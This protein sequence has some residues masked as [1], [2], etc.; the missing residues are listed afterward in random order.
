MEVIKVGGA[1]L[2]DVRGFNRFIK[3]LDEYHSKKII[4]VISAFSTST[5]DLSAIAQ[6]AS[7]G[8]AAKAYNLLNNFTKS[9]LELAKTLIKKPSDYDSLNNNLSILVEKLVSIIEGVIITKELSS[10]IKDLI[11]SFGEMFALQIV[12]SLLSA[13][14][15]KH[16]TI[17]ATKIIIT[18]S[19]FGNAKPNESVTERNVRLHL[20]PAFGECNIVLTQGFVASD[21]KGD[22]TTMGIESSNLTAVMLAKMSGAKKLTFWTDVPGIRSADPKL[23]KETSLIKGMSYSEAYTA[24]ALGL[25]LIYPSMIDYAKD[26]SIKLIYRSAFEKWDDATTISHKNSNPSIIITSDGYSLLEVIPKDCNHFSIAFTWLNELFANK[27]LEIMNVSF[28]KAKIAVLI[29]NSQLI[30]K[31]PAKLNLVKTEN[32][33]ISAFRNSDKEFLSKIKNL[34]TI[35][36]FTDRNFILILSDKKTQKEIVSKFNLKKVKTSQF[37]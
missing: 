32:L 14:S 13:H 33:C 3:I 10:R 24:G 30:D 8:K 26:N 2:R 4:I 1:V 31:Q 5:R 34:K 27:D 18:D 16:K 28:S 12:D 11:L 7:E 23:A 21:K 25:K 20:L 19:T 35:M 9:H 6:F 37:D 17:D 22:T 15:V 36:S 29:R